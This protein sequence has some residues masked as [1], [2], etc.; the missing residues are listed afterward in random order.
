M[1]TEFRRVLFDL[2]D[3]TP[4]P[5]PSNAK[6]VNARDAL[7]TRLSVCERQRGLFPTLVAVDFYRQGDV[8]GAVDELNRVGEAAPAAR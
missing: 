2:V 8:F 4:A 7:L 5:R 1:V 3:T 6:I